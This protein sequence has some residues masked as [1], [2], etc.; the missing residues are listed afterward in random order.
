M[1]DQRPRSLVAFVRALDDPG[2]GALLDALLE[3]SARLA[4]STPAGWEAE[5]LAALADGLLERL[6]ALG[7]RPIHKPG[8]TLSLTHAQLA[9]RYEYHGSPF[10][11][12]ERR[13][14]VVV[15]SPGWTV[16]RRVAVRPAVR[17]APP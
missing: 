4:A 16:G 15:V 3:A 1:P 9:G 14:R 17:E 5:T 8:E 7:V 6:A 10:R 12:G 11:P 2:R 13:K